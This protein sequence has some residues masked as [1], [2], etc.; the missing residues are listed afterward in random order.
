MTI[1][2]ELSPILYRTITTFGQEALHVDDDLVETF[3]PFGQFSVQ[4]LVGC[5]LGYPLV[6]L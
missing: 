1:I 5:S 2:S 6:K 3:E 4:L